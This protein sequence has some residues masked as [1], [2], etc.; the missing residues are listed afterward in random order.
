MTSSKNLQICPPVWHH[1]QKKTKIQNFPTL[2]PIQIARLFESLEAWT[3]LYPNR[4][5]SYGMCPNWPS[6]HFLGFHFL[7]RIWFLRYNF[8][9]RNARKPIIPLQTQIIAQLPKKLD[10]KNSSLGWRPRPGDL[11][12]KYVPQLWRNKKTQQPNFQ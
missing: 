5:V 6:I 9:T 10:P 3:A 8:G 7:P 4:L 11:G 2:F 12:Q 1:P